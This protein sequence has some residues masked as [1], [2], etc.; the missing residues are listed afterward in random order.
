MIGTFRSA[1][2]P[3][4]HMG[5]DPGFLGIRDRA[6]L[7]ILNRADVAT[8]AQLVRLVYRRRQTAQ[9]HLAALYR[10]GWLERAVLPPEDRGGAPLAFRLSPRARR[11]L[12][13]GPLTRARAGTQ[14]R[15]SLNIVETVAALAGLAAEPPDRHPVQAWLPESIT[16]DAGLAHVY[17]DSVVV[18]QLGATS[19]VLCLE[20]DQ[21][22]EHAP[23]IRG[24]L[25]RYEPALRSRAG[26]HVVFV[27]ESRARAAWLARVARDPGVPGLAGRT[28][29]IVL[30]DL[31]AAGVAA[32]AVPLG[33][34]G[35]R[36]TLRAIVA[37]PRSR[38]C[39]SPVASDAWLELLAS[40]GGEELAEALG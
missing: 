3:A 33:P 35:G 9:E 31:R 29:A 12:G 8:T 19:A 1:P 18:L 26:W 27:V 28:W 23:Q 10:A 20:I 6:A 5:L 21:A 32:V 40:G 4:R 34:M 17:P 22:T 30:A 16:R 38:R 36:P 15:H 13:Y 37:D 7:R 11:R 2:R 24:K 25:R 14:L 39:A